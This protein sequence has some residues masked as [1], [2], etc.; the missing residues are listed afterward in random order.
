M[1]LAGA[2]KIDG[3]AVRIR[4]FEMAGQK[5]RVRVPLA[6]EMELMKERVNNADYSENYQKLV[7]PFLEK[8]DLIKDEDIIFADDD[9]IVNGKSSKELAKS[10]A[11]M[12]AQIVEMFKLL[13]PVNG[14]DLSGLTIEDI[15]AEFPLS[16]QIE[17]SK[18]IS[19]V[20]S[21]G[22]EETRKN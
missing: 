2:L 1:N 4:S 14:E 7:A 19:E 12:S 16:I 5:L 15:D 10:S 21:P 13:V 22:Y 9:V 11:Q 17:I 6:S 18:K 8:K 3:N 20:I